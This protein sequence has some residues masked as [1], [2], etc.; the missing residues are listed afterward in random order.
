MYHNCV[1]VCAMGRSMTTGE[2]RFRSQ[3][4]TAVL[5]TRIAFVSY[6]PI[7]IL[8]WGGCVWV[9]FLGTVGLGSEILDE[10]DK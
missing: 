5:R 8:F 3:N 6:F 10:M 4:F 9:R 7:F 2:R 1:C